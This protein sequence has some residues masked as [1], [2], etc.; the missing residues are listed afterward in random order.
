MADQG[1]AINALFGVSFLPELEGFYFFNPK[2][3]YACKM[4][5]ECYFC[6]CDSSD[7][8]SLKDLDR[9]IKFKIKKGKLLLIEIVD[10]AD[11]HELSSILKFFIKNGVDLEGT[12]VLLSEKGSNLPID[13]ESL[14]SG[15]LEERTAYDAK[16][17]AYLLEFECIVGDRANGLGDYDKE[18]II[19]LI[20]KTENCKLKHYFSS[21][22]FWI[23]ASTNDL[24]FAKNIFK[25]DPNADLSLKNGDKVPLDYAISNYNDELVRLILDGLIQNGVVNLSNMINDYLIRAKDVVDRGSMQ[26][27][28]TLLKEYLQ[29]IEEA[30]NN[31]TNNVV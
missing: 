31:K 8:K 28:F 26:K 1:G 14:P 27:I 10:D 29:R 4:G 7:G 5:E 6:K 21:S 12:H 16:L 20:N 2:K 19:E 25:I 13:L 9:N 11:I 22:A 23:A 24:A 15:K 17:F 3:K 18:K 30:D